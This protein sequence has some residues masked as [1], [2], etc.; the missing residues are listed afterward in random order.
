MH[1]S[2]PQ[3][4]DLMLRVFFNVLDIFTCVYAAIGYFC[5]AIIAYS[6][7]HAGQ[8]GALTLASFTSEVFPAYEVLFNNWLGKDIVYII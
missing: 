3:Y 7:N 5:E 8:E 2:H 4:D 1:S 6:A